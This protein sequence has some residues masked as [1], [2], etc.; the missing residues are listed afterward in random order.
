MDRD[1]RQFVKEN[2]DLSRIGIA[3]LLEV[4]S[5]TTAEWLRIREIAS[6]AFRGNN[7]RDATTDKIFESAR[8][9]A[10]WV[11]IYDELKAFPYRPRAFTEIQKYDLTEEKNIKILEKSRSR[12]LQIIAQKY[13]NN[14]RIPPAA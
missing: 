3:R 10:D 2:R 4:Q 7:L 5:F 11:L 9:L 6:K 13:R 12:R 8:E 1:L 14:P